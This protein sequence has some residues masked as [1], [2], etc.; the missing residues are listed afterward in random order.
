[1]RLG[2]FCF[3]HETPRH[4]KWYFRSRLSQGWLGAATRKSE[5]STRLS[6]CKQEWRVAN[7][8]CFLKGYT[9]YSGTSAPRPTT[10]CDVP[11]V[12]FLPRNSQTAIA[13]PANSLVNSFMDLRFS[14]QCCGSK[15]PSRALAT[16]T[17]RSCGKTPRKM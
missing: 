7:V 16:L 9:T 4:R 8:G 6:R 11:R 12:L 13:I 3:P 10:D 17:A 5:H 2:I 15:S 14:H 1:M